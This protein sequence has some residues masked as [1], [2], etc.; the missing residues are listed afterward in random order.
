MVASRRLERL[1]QKREV[2][3]IPRLARYTWRRQWYA[4]ALIGMSVGIFQLTPFL[5]KRS[6][7]ATLAEVALLIAPRVVGPL[8]A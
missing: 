1:L 6:L 3:S 8:W 2:V 4:L 5:A 7:D